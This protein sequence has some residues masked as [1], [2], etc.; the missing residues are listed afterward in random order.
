M[1]SNNYMIY[2]ASWIGYFCS[3]CQRLQYSHRTCLRNLPIQNS[4]NHE[5]KRSRLLIFEG[6]GGHKQTKNEYSN[7]KQV[8]LHCEQKKVHQTALLCEP[9]QCH[10]R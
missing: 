10:S 8:S 9:Q 1:L 7:T 6:K 5:E 2:K 4:T 3:V